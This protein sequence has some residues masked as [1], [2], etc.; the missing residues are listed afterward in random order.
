VIV[1]VHIW[2]GD[3]GSIRQKALVKHGAACLRGVLQIADKFGELFHMV[4]LDLCKFLDENRVVSMMRDGVVS[5]RDADLRDCDF[6]EV[7]MRGVDFR[8]A[9][10]RGSTGL[11]A[12]QIAESITDHLTKLP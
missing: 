12:Q 7:R 9:N 3:A 10:L 11:T 4:G 8:G 5:F 1:I 2:V 6:R